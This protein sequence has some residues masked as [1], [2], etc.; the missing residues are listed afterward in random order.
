[1]TRRALFEWLAR[2]VGTACAAIVAVPAVR[3][4]IDPLRRQPSGERDF[5]RITRLDALPTGVP[6]E[7]A[8]RDIR[9]DAWTLHPEETIGRVWL[10]RRDDSDTPPE[11]TNVDVLASLCPHLGCAIQLDRT[12]K[13]FACPCHKAGFRL[14]GER[15]DEKELGHKNPAPRDMDSLDC[16]IVQDDDSGQWWVEVR[17]QKFKRGLTTKVPVV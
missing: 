17:F 11:R 5:K 10:V 15:L 7:F 6:R 16:R 12:G 9:Q 14:S 1:M 8:V 13:K 2:A 4:L 3:Y